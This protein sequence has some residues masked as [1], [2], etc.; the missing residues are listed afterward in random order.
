MNSSCLIFKLI[1]EKQPLNLI[2]VVNNINLLNI[3]FQN[4][5]NF[6]IQD[7]YNFY[8]LDQKSVAYLQDH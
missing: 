2:I 8:N 4:M 1:L 3:E 5:I 7:F 6:K